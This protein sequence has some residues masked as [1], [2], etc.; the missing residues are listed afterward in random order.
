MP[1]GEARVNA[2][3]HG[4]ALS[5]LAPFV[6]NRALSRLVQSGALSGRVLARYDTG[7][8]TMFGGD[9]VVFVKDDVKI[10][11]R[12][13][14][15]LGDLYERVDDVYAADVGE[16]RTLVA[17][18]RRDRDAYL[19][20]NNA[21]SVSNSEWEAAT[22]QGAHRSKTF[23]DLAAEND[24]HFAPATSGH[25]WD[26]KTAKDY[27][28]EWRRIHKQ[29][30]DLARGAKTAADRQRAYAFNAFAGHFLTDAFS[31]GHMINKQ[32]TIARAKAS[33]DGLETQYWIFHENE[34]TKKVAEAVLADPVAGRQLRKY[35]IRIVDW[36]EMSAEHLSELLWQFA[37]ND[38]YREKFYDNFVKSVHDELS[39]TGIQVSNPRGDGPWVLRG[40]THLMPD[41][42]KTTSKDKYEASRD[43]SE[44]TLRVGR[45]AFAQ[46]VKNISE[47]V[48]STQPLDYEKLFERVWAYVPRPTAKGDSHIREVSDRLLNLRNPEAIKTF[49]RIVANNVDLLIRKLND[50][51][52]DRLESPDEIKGM[53]GKPM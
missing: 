28:A 32:E 5:E 33:W 19:G 53:P 29:A 31:A 13:M 18:I 1:G 49:A 45:A 6:G 36:H 34:F 11:E 25:A 4:S 14:L 15:T 27:K 30:L 47:A 9:D 24:T 20:L 44:N 41:D 12:E 26:W 46:S 10:T 39:D 40:D 50:P 37:N 43:S 2:S 38:E 17:L 21:R 51:S 52:V 16:L 8:H 22:P 7:E 35:W 23:L 3:L 42:P 48:G